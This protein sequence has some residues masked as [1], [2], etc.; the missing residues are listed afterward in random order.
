MIKG[1]HG[2][3][4]CYFVDMAVVSATVGSL[5]LDNVRYEI[6]CYDI[7][8]VGKFRHCISAFYGMN[9]EAI[10][11]HNMIEMPQICRVLQ[12]KNIKY[13]F[14]RCEKQCTVVTDRK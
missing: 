7:Y 12:K 3:Y 14:Y 6:I 11:G 13:P 8:K 4:Y 2:H 1:C 10:L 5:L 9:T